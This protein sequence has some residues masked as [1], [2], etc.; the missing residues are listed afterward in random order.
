MAVAKNYKFPFQNFTNSLC[1]N[2]EWYS[3]QRTD[4]SLREHPVSFTWL[5]S[6]AYFIPNYR[7]EFRS[8][9]QFHS[10]S[11]MRNSYIAHICFSSFIPK[12]WIER[13]K[14]RNEFHCILFRIVIDRS[15]SIHSF[16][17]LLFHWRTF[18]E[19]HLLQERANTFG[20]K[21]PNNKV[22]N[23]KLKTWGKFLWYPQ[24]HQTE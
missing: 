4:F 14:R 16:S 11:T 24:G 22:F 17:N 12:D 18:L 6:M 1:L 21:L 2:K 19:G 13:A 3:M 10:S 9:Y 15:G 5:K 23:S 8:F 20:K 7:K